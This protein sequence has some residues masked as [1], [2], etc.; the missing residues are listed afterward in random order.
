[1]PVKAVSFQT[2]LKHENKIKI[3]RNF[4]LKYEVLQAILH[5]FTDSVLKGSVESRE[6]Q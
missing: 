3:K 5:L 6:L 2:P 4:T 1:M